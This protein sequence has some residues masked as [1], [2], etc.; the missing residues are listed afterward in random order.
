MTQNRINQAEKYFHGK[1]GYNCAQ[2]ILKAY[3]EIFDVSEEKIIE[4]KAFGGGRADQ[5]IC[6][7]LF[8]AMEL[9][10]DDQQ[11]RQLAKQKFAVRVNSTKCKDI[12]QTGQVSC[13]E[14]VKIAAQIVEEML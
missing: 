10:K 1:E 7:A 9:F 2:A 3:Q 13:R 14:C 6:G 5:G 4:F 8:A 12:R 11:K